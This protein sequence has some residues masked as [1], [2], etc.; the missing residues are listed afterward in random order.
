MYSLFWATLYIQSIQAFPKR[1]LP[2]LESKR[3]DSHWLYINVTA[4]TEQYTVFLCLN[5]HLRGKRFDND[6]AVKREHA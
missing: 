6:D 1:W 5:H 2:Y 4:M 3:S